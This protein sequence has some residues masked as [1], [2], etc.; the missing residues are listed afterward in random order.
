MK[1]LPELDEAQNKIRKDAYKRNRRKAH[2]WAAV[3]AVLGISASSAFFGAL[4]KA[5]D[6]DT[7]SNYNNDSH[8]YVQDSRKTRNNFNNAAAGFGLILGGLVIGAGAVATGHQAGRH[9]DRAQ[10]HKDGNYFNYNK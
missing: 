2:G 3:T 9:Y 4:G 1:N 7:N 5:A 10:K 6:F 8:T